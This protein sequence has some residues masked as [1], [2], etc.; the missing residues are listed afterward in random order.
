[1]LTMVNMCMMLLTVLNGI[2]NDTTI[3][4]IDNQNISD[5]CSKFNIQTKTEYTFVSSRYAEVFVNKVNTLMN[6]NWV[7]QGGISV[8]GYGSSNWQTMYS[9]AFIRNTLNNI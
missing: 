9:Q 4:P 2:K 8:H 7:P 5:I 1:M 3:V 6:D